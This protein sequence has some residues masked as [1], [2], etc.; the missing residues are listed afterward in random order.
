M[1]DADGL[2]DVQRR[3]RDPLGERRP[4]DQLQN[5]RGRAARLFD[6]VNRRD[7]RMAQRREDFRL[8]LK[9]RG[10]L[11]IARHRLRQH[12]DRDVALQPRVARAIDLAHASGAER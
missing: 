5:Q 11:G 10:A 3:E 8:A 9:A 2:G 6:A 12:L 1:R 7:V 4:F